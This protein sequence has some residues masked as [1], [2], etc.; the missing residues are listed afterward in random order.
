MFTIKV[1]EQKY[2][3]PA[4]NKKVGVIFNG[5]TR[6]VA[7]D[8]WT[9]NNG[10]AHFSEDNGNGTVYVSGEK[11]YEGDIEGRIVVYK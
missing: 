3:T 10:E 8:Q 5:W 6:G 9:D 2:G 7:K 4:A 11:V 1:I